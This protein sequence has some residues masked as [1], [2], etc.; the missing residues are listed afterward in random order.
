[1]K[2]SRE[3]ESFSHF[4]KTAQ[5]LL[6]DRV[7][8]AVCAFISACYRCNITIILPFVALIV[9][10]G[11]GKTQL[12]VALSYVRPI[13]Y[14]VRQCG[15]ATQD[16]YKNFESISETFFSFVNRDLQ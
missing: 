12:A 1:M 9:R 16:F 3:N 5:A 15:A 8:L 7:L 13:L 11:A 6:N 10:S 14:L 2:P 4:K